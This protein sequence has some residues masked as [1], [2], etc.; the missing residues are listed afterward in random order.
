MTH[1]EHSDLI[2]ELRE[3]RAIIDYLQDK[4]ED[5]EFANTSLKYMLNKSI[6][7]ANMRD[8]MDSAINGH[9]LN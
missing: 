9:K 5:L 4:N 8:I 3:A 7:E 6:N 2:N 1:S